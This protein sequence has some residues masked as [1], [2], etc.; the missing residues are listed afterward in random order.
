[1]QQYVVAALLLRTVHSA[2]ISFFADSA[3]SIPNQPYNAT[4]YAS[5]CTDV[6]A[7]YGLGLTACSPGVSATALMFYDTRP[8]APILRP[9]RCGPPA[10]PIATLAGALGV[11]TPVPPVIMPWTSGGA[12]A[13]YWKWTELSCAP[14][15]A[16]TPL[17]YA[18][19]IRNRTCDNI[20]A[21]GELYS[22]I[23]ADGRCQAWGDSLTLGGFYRL[24]ATLITAGSTSSLALSA[25]ALSD[26]ACGGA[27][28]SAWPALPFPAS[29]DMCMPNA[30][31]TGGIRVLSPLPAY[32]PPAPSA[33]PAPPQP[34]T[35]EPVVLLNVYAS[36]PCTG[37]P[38]AGQFRAFPGICTANLS[39]FVDVG[40]SACAVGGAVDFAVFNQTVGLPGQCAPGALLLNG[41]ATV[42]GCA[43]FTPPFAG[44][45]TLFVS[46]AQPPASCAPVSAAAAATAA[47][48]ENP[49]CAGSPSIVSTNLASGR[50]GT[51]MVTDTYN[52]SATINTA[53]APATMSVASFAS[54]AAPGGCSGAGSPFG[55]TVPLVTV[56]NAPLTGACSPAL[57]GFL[58]WS[59]R[60]WPA[61]V[62]APPALPSPSTGASA[63]DAASASPS[64]SSTVSASPT[65]STSTGA[66]SST[67]ASPSNTATASPTP[68]V[69]ASPT[70]SLSVGSSPSVS[71]SASLSQSPGGVAPGG[72]TPSPT[73][74]SSSNGGGA[75]AA[76]PSAV[77][78]AVGGTFGGLFLLAV[79]GG[80]LF[81]V[82]QA[83]RGGRLGAR[84]KLSP[85]PGIATSVVV[86]NA[87]HQLNPLS[88]PPPTVVMAPPVSAPPL[89]PGGA[90]QTWERHEDAGD[91]WYVSSAGDT[92]WELPS[93]AVLR[94]SAL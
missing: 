64:A 19:Q 88:A 12:G 83:R 46:L 8:S 3:C 2:R 32:T 84:L 60:A 61:R 10:G 38:T 17:L 4:A 86:V 28:L 78:P 65:A 21:P 93:G 37:A 36:A 47:Y 54:P 94:G 45:A 73:A 70:A 14:P 39:P 13:M 87:A 92:A 27:P 79:L 53:A 52:Y 71:E 57:Y 31:G 9:P 30:Q 22:L 25:Y 89:Q 34:L 20:P 90:A 63:S 68:T 81:Y 66:S 11:C 33:S 1:M 82:L 56:A 58:Q 16:S 67:G 49:A 80:A 15:P 41:T 40:L 48:F 75:A 35:V 55:G 74:S 85:G 77:G 26:T 29:A 62:Y 59:V 42:G 18:A 24:R 44:G 7:S 72:G 51:C 91:V 5:M 43:A 23:V 76:A 6:T 69:C 50:P